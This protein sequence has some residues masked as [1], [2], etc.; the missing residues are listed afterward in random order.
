MG[1]RSYPYRRFRRERP[2]RG[3]WCR[4]LGTTPRVV[5]LRGFSYPLGYLVR[6]LRSVRLHLAPLGERLLQRPRCSVRLALRR[7][8]DDLEGE[9]A[10]ALL[11][12]AIAP[13][14]AER[15]ERRLSP[16]QQ[17]RV[18]G[19]RALLA[20]SPTTR[21][22]LRAVADKVGCSPF[23][24]AREF[25]RGTGQSLSRYVLQLR[26]A[27]AI[28]RLV[29]GENNLSLLALELGFSHHSHFSARFRGIFGTTPSAARETLTSARRA[30][31]VALVATAPS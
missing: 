17:A 16:G 21:W 28:E 24:L 26:L 11:V 8:Q 22:T 19:V 10:A 14:F 9:D 1:R 6:S 18:E 7:A 27:L 3:L 15:A 2:R 31:L 13:A 25:R 30:E 12:D 4:A 23:H 29:G 20:T 5:S